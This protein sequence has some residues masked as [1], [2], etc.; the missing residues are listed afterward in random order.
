LLFAGGRFHLKLRGDGTP[1]SVRPKRPRTSRT[2]P[3]V[4]KI[5]CGGSPE[6]RP[7][8]ALTR[9]LEDGCLEIDNNIAERAM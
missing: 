9:Y 4:W 8:P 5:C 1:P 3:P 6:N 7:W 2:G